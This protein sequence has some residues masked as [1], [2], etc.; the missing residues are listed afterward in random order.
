MDIRIPRLAEGVDAGT[1]VSILVKEGDVIQKDQTVLEIE[2]KKAVAPIPAQEGGTVTKVHVKEGQEVAVGQV[3]ISL[4]PAGAKQE[5][6]APPARK[7]EPSGGQPEPARPP[8]RAP[9]A[10]EPAYTN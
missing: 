7:T 2:T 6:A 8:Q 9:R 4:T 10:A 5:A 3:V 1:V